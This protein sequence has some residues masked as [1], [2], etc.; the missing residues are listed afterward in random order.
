VAGHRTLWTLICVSLYVC[1]IWFVIRVWWH[2][3]KT[4]LC[5]G[6]RHVVGGGALLEDYIKRQVWRKIS[7]V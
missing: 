7:D 2:W 3:T 5:H 6:A 1:V 4:Y